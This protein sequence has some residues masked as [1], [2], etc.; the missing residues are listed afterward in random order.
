LRKFSKIIGIFVAS[1]LTLVGLFKLIPSKSFI[2]I[3]LHN[4]SIKI[5]SD[6]FIL[7]SISLLLLFIGILLI[8]TMIYDIKKEKKKHIFKVGSRRFCS[9][10]SKWYSRPGTLSIICDDLEGW[11]SSSILD[12]LIKK[13]KTKEL[14][15]F[16]G[17]ESPKEIINE[18]CQLG[19]TKSCA[20]TDIIIKYS[21]SCLSIMGNHSAVIVRNK[22]L[23]QSTSIIFEEISDSY[24]S[25]LLNTII[26]EGIGNG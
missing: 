23:D 8:V 1:L 11:V 26:K 14:H 15:L 5:N 21:F 13:S 10:F 16:L 4:L 9:F 19:A 7:S 24:V 20:P 2:G 22:Q 18:L 17:K 25:G 6:P 3:C 12:A